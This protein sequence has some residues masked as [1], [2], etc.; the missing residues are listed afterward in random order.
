MLIK[1]K[2]KDFYDSCLGY[3]VDKKVVYDRAERVISES[4]YEDG[5]KIT[6]VKPETNLLRN[7]CEPWGPELSNYSDRWDFDNWIHQRKPGKVRRSSHVVALGFCG[8]VHK[9]LVD[10][11][12]RSSAFY[13]QVH[14]S[15]ETMD[16]EL[17]DG[18]S[19]FR[20]KTR[21]EEF[22]E[23]Q[24]RENNEIF[25]AL[26]APVF[27]GWNDKIIVNPCLKEL[28]FHKLRDG[29]STFQELSAYISSALTPTVEPEPISDVL[30]AQ[31]HG[32]DK[33]SFRKGK[34][35]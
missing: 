12:W 6:S 13:R 15:V 11:G 4:W 22:S 27:V 25:Q 34:Q 7:I 3:G 2:F 8:V 1:S 5:K 18:K 20:D 33:H 14:F 32:F 26:H 30:R 17:A 10:H 21:R 9:V 16:E 19:F 29:V 24:S 35:K 31:T 28:G 23:P